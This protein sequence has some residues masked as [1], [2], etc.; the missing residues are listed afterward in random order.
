M[1]SLICNRRR[2]DELILVCNGQIYINIVQYIFRD[3]DTKTILSLKAAL[4]PEFKKL[5]SV[6]TIIYS[7]SINTS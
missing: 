7:R 5:P 2:G 1:V 6:S 3:I 4:T